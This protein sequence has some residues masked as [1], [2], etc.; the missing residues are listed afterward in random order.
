LTM[1]KDWLK[2]FMGMVQGMSMTLG[3]VS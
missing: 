3:A 1:D 2:S